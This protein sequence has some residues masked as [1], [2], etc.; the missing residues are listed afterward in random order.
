VVGFD[1]ALISDHYHPWVDRQG[2]RGFVWPPSAVSP[3]RPRSCRSVP[4]SGALGS[5]GQAG[6]TRRAATTSS[7]ER[8]DVRVQ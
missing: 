6:R 1:F 8:S 5:V 3:R 4:G 7:R 2:H